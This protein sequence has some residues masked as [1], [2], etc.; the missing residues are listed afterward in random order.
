MV[1]R[2]ELLDRKNSDR[3]GRRRWVRRKVRNVVRVYR[4]RPHGLRRVFRGEAFVGGEVIKV[5]CHTWAEWPWGHDEV[6]S[7]DCG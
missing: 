1:N 7:D 4:P 5:W 6:W 2:I 3:V